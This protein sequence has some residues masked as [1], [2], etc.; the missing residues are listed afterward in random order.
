MD[1]TQ[2]RDWLCGIDLDPNGR[3]AL[4]VSDVSHS[5]IRRLVTRR[6]TLIDNE[7]YGYDVRD[8]LHRDLTPRQYAATEAEVRFEVQKEPRVRSASVSVSAPAFRNISIQINYQTQDG[9]QTLTLLV[10]DVTVQALRNGR[11]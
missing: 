6:G 5:I 3:E 7:D 1:Y 2:G 11:S 8:L 9:E 4:G 10:N